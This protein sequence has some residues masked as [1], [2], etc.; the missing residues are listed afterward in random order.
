MRVDRLPFRYIRMRN[1]ETNTRRY[2]PKLSRIEIGVER[3]LGGY[4]VLG[5]HPSFTEIDTSLPKS[6][7]FVVVKHAVDFQIS[8]HCS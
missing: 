2:S 8:E 3:H 4:M 5:N 6:S 7:G 1:R